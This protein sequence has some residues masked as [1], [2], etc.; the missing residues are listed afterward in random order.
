MKN[1]TLLSK[2]NHQI[3]VII[4]LILKTE[5]DTVKRGLPVY[6]VKAVPRHHPVLMKWDGDDDYDGNY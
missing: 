2:L 1:C 4:F 3:F 5:I 6:K